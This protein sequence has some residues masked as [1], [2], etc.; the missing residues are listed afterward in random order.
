MQNA[1]M[2]RMTR[3]DNYNIPCQLWKLMLSPANSK[4]GKVGSTY[5]SVKVGC[6]WPWRPDW[7]CGWEGDGS[8]FPRTIKICVT[9]CGVDDRFCFTRH[10]TSTKSPSKLLNVVKVIR[11]HSTGNQC[12]IDFVIHLHVYPTMCMCT[13]TDFKLFTSC[14]WKIWNQISL[15]IL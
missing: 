8:W 2:R 6:A 14:D 12:T 11:L 5:N 3:A 10:V 13:H 7:L 15:E 1:L 4:V 9:S